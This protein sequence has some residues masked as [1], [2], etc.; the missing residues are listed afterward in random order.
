MKKFL[1]CFLILISLFGFG[2]QSQPKVEDTKEV[3][4]EVKEEPKK[5]EPK[6]L[7]NELTPQER[8]DSAI[9]L[10]YPLFE[11]TGY[12]IELVDDL[13]DY[14]KPDARGTCYYEDKKILVE[15]RLLDE[16]TD[17]FDI[18]VLHE[19]GHAIDY[20]NGLLSNTSEFRNAYSEANILLSVKE[21]KYTEDDISY[22]SSSYL[23]YFAESYALYKLK[24]KLVQEN[25]PLT[26]EFFENNMK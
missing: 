8:I 22:G 6:S 9:L 10:S 16:Y 23:E 2:C 13:A 7:K 25:A 17:V 21:L 1:S 20:E 14:G 3:V 15:F 4:E 19:I 5:E 24:S 18:T 26:Y 11:N 12:T